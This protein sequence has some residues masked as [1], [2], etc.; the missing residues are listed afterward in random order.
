V[1]VV[2]AAA[3]VVAGSAAALNAQCAARHPSQLPFSTPCTPC[4][5][6]PCCCRRQATPN[7]DTA[8]LFFETNRLGFTPEV[9]GQ[10]R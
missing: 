4:C 3:M 8:M 10:I 2:A 9:L 7:A 5:P 6:A 1:V